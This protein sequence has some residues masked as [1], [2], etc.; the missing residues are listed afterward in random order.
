MGNGANNA[1]ENLIEVKGDILG[2]ESQD[3]VPILL[4]QGIL[5]AVA[6]V[7]FGIGEVLGTVEFEDEVE[8]FAG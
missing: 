6:P 1:I 4:K 3:E 8:I 2:Q 7:G 5:A